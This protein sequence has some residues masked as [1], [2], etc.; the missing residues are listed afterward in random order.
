MLNYPLSVFHRW[1]EFFL[2][3]KF[4][5]AHLL[6]DMYVSHVYVQIRNDCL[7]T[8]GLDKD[9]IS[10]NRPI[11]DPC[12]PSKSSELMASV[13]TTTTAKKKSEFPDTNSSS[14][15]GRGSSSSELPNTAATSKGS[16]SD[17]VASNWEEYRWHTIPKMNIF[18][19]LYQWTSTTY[20]CYA[21]VRDLLPIEQI[22][23][24]MTLARP[25]RCYL[26]G[27]FVFTAPMNRLVAD[28]LSLLHLSWR[29]YQYFRPDPYR[30]RFVHFMMQNRSELD[31][32]QKLVE[33]CNTAT[34]ND[35]SHQSGMQRM[36]LDCSCYRIL[37]HNKV[38]YRLRPNRTY[39]SY[40]RIATTMSRS[41]L[42]SQ[43]EF[44][45]LFTLVFCYVIFFLVQVERYLFEYPGCYPELESAEHTF[46]SLDLTGHHLVS[47]FTDG[48]ESLFFW[49][50]SGLAVTY[51]V[52]LVYLLNKDTLIYWH[53]MH[54]RVV[55]TLEK[56]RTYWL[57]RQTDSD[58]FLFGHTQE[59]VRVEA[60]VPPSLRLKYIELG[61]SMK[62]D[63]ALIPNLR[64]P[65]AGKQ[66]RGVPFE[67]EDLIAE[68]QAEI[69]DFFHQ[70]G[71]TDKFVS[72]SIRMAIII[73]L[74]S[75][76][77][78]YY[79]PMGT[80]T[81]SSRSGLL[82]QLFGLIVVGSIMISLAELHRCTAKTYKSICSLMAYDQSK[83]K[84]SFL[85]ILE[86]YSSR[87]KSS[88][89]LI[90]NYHLTTTTFLSLVGWTISCFIILESLFRESS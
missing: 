84:R 60:D 73:W 26:M 64:T 52:N 39:D 90:Q 10:A 23:N 36:A 25:T 22:L 38:L 54:N 5:R 83:H 20:M 4:L 13:K 46:W 85:R 24:L 19:A 70:V 1:S 18:A 44:A 49:L 7:H 6:I 67:L 82:F 15:A 75:F 35:H 9:L 34:N 77:L 81:E 61:S 2:Q 59:G 88:F 12:P 48:F 29:S 79:Y 56:T 89:T 53:H 14:S 37:K 31:K 72:D 41:I 86:F 62:G 33:H 27:H 65:W 47:F 76:A 42:F 43:I 57:M 16:L 66:L 45:V 68:T 58:R 63:L 50:D 80:G 28:L 30:L 17:D 71:E 32:L 3:E 55:S 21:L 51:V 78:L 69:F 8:Y 87:G 11:A 40:K 74:S